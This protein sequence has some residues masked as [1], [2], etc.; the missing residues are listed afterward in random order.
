MCAGAIYWAGVG[1]V[2]Y[3]LGQEGFYALGG[4][5]SDGLLLHCR[6]VFA[7]GRHAVDV[8]GPALEAEAREVHAGFWTQL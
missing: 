8:L 7:R 1:R 4:E 6:D 5:G 2:V 3:G